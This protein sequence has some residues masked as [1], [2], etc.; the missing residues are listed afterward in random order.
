MNNIDFSLILPSRERIPVL[1]GLLDSI[2]DTTL[3]QDRIEC[4]VCIDWDDRES[5]AAKRDLEA[6]YPWLSMITTARQN[7]MTAGYYTP[8]AL[9]SNG[10][11]VQ[12][13]NDDARFTTPGWD[14]SALRVLESYKELHPDGILYGRTWDDLGAGY[15][16]FPLLSRE[17]IE[18]AGWCFHPEFPTWGADIHLH[19][20]YH[21]LQRIVDMPYSLRH[22]QQRDHINHRMRDNASY[23]WGSAPGEA[24]RLWNIIQ[25]KK[26][27][28]AAQ[29]LSQDR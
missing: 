12:V 21:Q 4:L 6:K 20:I 2:K 11:Y 24:H 25:E 15:S 14:Q 29:N 22:D 16:C 23:N 3:K 8:M 19:Q 18:A 10:R 17:A 7:N 1:T 27:A 13:L 5:Q 28:L 26:A 9:F